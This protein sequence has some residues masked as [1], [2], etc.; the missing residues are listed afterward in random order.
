[1]KNRVTL[2]DVAE[3]VGVTPATVSMV[4]SNKK[5][6]SQSTRERVLEAVKELNY[7]PNRTARNLVKGKTETIA[8]MAEF[9]YPQFF[10]QLLSGI[11]HT[12]SKTDYSITHYSTLRRNENIHEIFQKILFGRE[13][14]ALICFDILP[15]PEYIKLFQEFNI[16]LLTMEV[17]SPNVL[18]IEC[19]NFK[20]GYLAGK[21]LIKCGKKN[22]Y[23]AA[24]P[25]ENLHAKSNVQQLRIDGFRKALKE[26]GLEFHPET[27]IRIDHFSLNEGLALYKKIQTIEKIDGLFS[28]AGDSVAIGLMH[29]MKQDGLRIPEDLAVI[30]FDNLEYSTYCDPPLTTVNQPGYLMGQGAARAI[31]KQLKLHEPVFEKLPNYSP[32]LIIRKTC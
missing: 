24:V 7:Y 31:L 14:D 10:Q 3:K 30:G 4:L 32:E 28:A 12:I 22:I 6:I 20:G 21:Y 16:P 25:Q 23:C 27:V 11:E 19:D 1:M 17:S 26:E 9:F 8:I 13:A 18:S 15:D 2:K 5:N 29:Y